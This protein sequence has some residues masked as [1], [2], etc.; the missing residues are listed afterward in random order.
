LLFLQGKSAQEAASYLQGRRNVDVTFGPSGYAQVKQI[1]PEEREKRVQESLRN[2]ANLERLVENTAQ[3]PAV[4]RAAMRVLEGDTVGMLQ[5]IKRG[6]PS[7]LI[8]LVAGSMAQQPDALALVSF[9]SF[10]PGGAAVGGFTGATAMESRAV[11]LEMLREDG[12]D[13]K[14]PVA[15]AEKLADPKF[16][17]KARKVGG[18]RGGVIGVV[19]MLA[20]MATAGIGASAMRPIVKSVLGVGVQT[21]GE[22][23]G[24]SLAMVASGQGYN[25]AEAALE[26][27][28]GGGQS[29]VETGVIQKGAEILQKTFRDPEYQALLDEKAKLERQIQRLE[30]AGKRRGTPDLTELLPLTQRLDEVNEEITRFAETK[31]AETAPGPEGQA[32]S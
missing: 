2:V 21:A 11:L 15:V 31:S 19:D 4:R 24:E 26:A 20:N 32:P 14:D 22:Y 1:T 7:A 9:M 29:I 25:P 13:L 30:R 23:T 5:E 18:I 8:A 27:V 16:Y 3:H 17:D 6:G 28:A 12:V 10:L